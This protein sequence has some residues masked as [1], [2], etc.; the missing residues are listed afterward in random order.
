MTTRG[1]MKTELTTDLGTSAFS[2]SYDAFINRAIA[3]HQVRRWFQETR[4]KTFS[5]V[6]DQNVYSVDDDADIGL[7]IQLDQLFLEKSNEDIE[8]DVMTIRD[9]EIL[10]DGAASSGEPYEYAYYEKKIHLYR[11]PDQAYTMRMHGIFRTA[12]PA[13]DAEADNPWMTEAF[14]LI[15]AEVVRRIALHRMKDRELVSMAV[16]EITVQKA[17][18]TK[19]YEM[20]HATRRLKPTVF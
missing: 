13:S 6:A 15:K 2:G 5:T 14:D 12:A 7:I 10:A 17:R 9:W 19:E 20:K 8:L 11:T 3:D 4:S 1:D 18:L 16:G